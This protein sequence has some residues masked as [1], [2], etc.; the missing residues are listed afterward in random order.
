MKTFKFFKAV[1]FTLIV[2]LTSCVDKDFDPPDT[3]GIPFDPDKI[4]TVSELRAFTDDGATK[5]FEE[6]YSV[7]VTVT[8]D[9]KSGNIYM[10][11]FAQDETGG[12][13][14]RLRSPGGLYVGDYIRINLRNTTVSQYQ[15]LV[16]LDSV[17]VDNNIE[18]LA[19]WACDVTINGDPK[20]VVEPEV[21][22]IPVIG[23]DAFQSQL[24]KLNDVQFASY[25]VGETYADSEDPFTAYNRI[26]M[27]CDGN[28]IIVRTSGF[29]V[30][31]DDEIPE[32]NGSVIAIASRYRDDYQL[33]LRSSSEVNLD[34]ARCN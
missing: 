24:I 12:I 13:N 20:P 19:T 3:E 6:D 17:H 5:R 16:Q 2:G 21:V 28:E 32:G 9:D 30:F 31:A 29:A 15:N 34:G 25:E 7:F 10:A 33:L 23:S 27:D 4:H 26:L 1:A 18:K 14:L 11:A 8:M 22:T